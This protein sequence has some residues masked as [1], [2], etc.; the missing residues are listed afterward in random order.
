V[1]IDGVGNLSASRYDVQG[2]VM[3]RKQ[4][5]GWDAHVHFGIGDR[6]W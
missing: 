4:V 1:Q 5:R 2:I 3:R 6:V